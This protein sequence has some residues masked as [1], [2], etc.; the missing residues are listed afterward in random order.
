[1]RT[2]VLDPERNPG[3][4]NL[5]QLDGRVIVIDYAHNTAGMESLT[6]VLRGLCRLDRHVW[7]AIGAAGD[8][9]DAILH[10]FSLRAAL[11]S[12]HLA[13]AE[14]LRYLRGRAPQD[15]VD[16]LREGAAQAGVSGV[17]AYPDELEALRAMLDSSRPR[18]VVAVTALAKRTE[19]FA[20]LG[21]VGATR[22]KPATIRRLVRRVKEER[23]S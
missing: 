20:W 10:S 14:L 19:I 6:E 22:M 21:S 8:R 18:D 9:S 23:G 12:D 15:V 5:F 17:P 2:F 1:L 7:L 4:A 3:R 13:I 16:R 11:G